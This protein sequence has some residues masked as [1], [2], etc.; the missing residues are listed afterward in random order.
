MHFIRRSS[1]LLVVFGLALAACASSDQPAL[2]DSFTDLA[3]V[4][5]EAITCDDL[6]ELRP[7]YADADVSVDADMLRTD[8][9]NL[10]QIQ[11][12]VTRAGADYGFELTD[13]MIEDRVSDPPLRWAEAMSPDRTEGE[14]RRDAVMTLVHDAVVSGVI[15]EEYGDAAAYAAE[16]PQ[17]LAKMCVRV[18]VLADQQSADTAVDRIRSGEDFNDV[19]I[20]MSLDQQSDGLIVGQ[21]G[22]CPTNVA[23]LGEEF[24][25]AALEAPIGEVEGPIVVQQY[26]VVYQVEERILPGES[27][28]LETD[29]LEALDLSVQSARF[30]VWADGVLA[31]TDVEVASP[32]GRWSTETLA[33][34]PPGVSTSGG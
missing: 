15:A 29:L 1:I 21:D 20:E 23:F 13:Q 27:G 16:R 22:T 18:I 25:S 12:F 3:V 26:F 10:I 14:L 32:V 33:I 19:R 17:D 8:L 11:A 2:C 24:A 28:D 4:N 30:G 31:A 5:G 7:E 34:V 9:Q 6:V